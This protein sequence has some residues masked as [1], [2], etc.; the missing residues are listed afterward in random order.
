MNDVM[1]TA[2]TATEFTN[3]NVLRNKMINVKL[4]LCDEVQDKLME[5]MTILPTNREFHCMTVTS[6]SYI[7]TKLNVLTPV[8]SLSSKRLS[9]LQNSWKFEYICRID[10]IIISS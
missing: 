5:Q 2:V 8:F 3:I 6:T 1:T 7:L 9:A 4:L 10:Q